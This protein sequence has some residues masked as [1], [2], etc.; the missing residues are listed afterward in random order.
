MPA[1]QWLNGKESTCNAG[2]AGDIG[3]IPWV[4]KIPWGR[5]WQPT[6]VFL[7]G[8][9]HEWENLVGYSP[10]GCKELD[11]NEVTEHTRTLTHH[12][13]Q[14]TQLE[15][16]SGKGHQQGDVRRTEVCKFHS[17]HQRDDNNV[18]NYAWG[19]ALHH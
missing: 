8:E 12:G 4:G 3:L 10:W 16:N 17:N 5:A 14:H 1:P 19:S 18:I 13:A 7:P 11:T 2:D 15:F 9:S 6:P